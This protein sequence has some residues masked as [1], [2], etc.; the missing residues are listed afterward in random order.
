MGIKF[1]QVFITTLLL[2]GVTINPSKSQSYTLQSINGNRAQF[3]LSLDDRKQILSITCSND[4][5]H[6]P[7]V[8]YIEIA[9]VLRNKFLTVTYGV[10]AGV[11]MSES[12]TLILSASNNNICQSLHITS[13]FKERFMD[14]SRPNPPSKG[15]VKTVFNL[16]T[17]LT[18]RNIE[19]YKLHAEIHSSRKSMYEPR[20]NYNYDYTTALNFDSIQNI[21]YSSHEYIS[22]RFTIF[23]PRIGSETTK[24]VKDTLPVINL[25]QDK[26]FYM[27]GVWYEISYKSYLTQ[28]SYR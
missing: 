19:S 5:V 3:Q 8:E 26:Y 23:D 22:Q 12:R 28:Y 6:I 4:T 2:T 18:G 21:F 1:N 17:L 13:S 11:G 10:R 7:N 15:S 20:T 14:F 27:K 25:A 24:Y 9:K 16:N